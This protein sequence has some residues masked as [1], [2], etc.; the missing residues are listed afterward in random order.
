[1]E[2]PAATR[3]AWGT[4]E[5]EIALGEMP[6]DTHLDVTA[7]FGE[8]LNATGTITLDCSADSNGDAI[9]VQIEKEQNVRLN[10]R[11]CDEF[12]SDEAVQ[13]GINQ[14]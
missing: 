7:T 1:M 2:V 8:S 3:D 10:E 13:G 12:P 4:V 11:C 14:S 5:T 6:D 9:S